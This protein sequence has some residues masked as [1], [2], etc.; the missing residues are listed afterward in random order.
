MDKSRGERFAVL[1]IYLLGATFEHKTNI[2]L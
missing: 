2:L 1:C